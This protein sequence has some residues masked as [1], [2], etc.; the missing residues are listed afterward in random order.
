MKKGNFR[1]IL[2]AVMCLVMSCFSLSQ[3]AAEE[4]RETNYATVGENLVWTTTSVHYELNEFD[5]PTDTLVVK[6]Y[7]VNYSNKYV[8][9]F[10][11]LN[12]IVTV[13]KKDSNEEARINAVFKNF[14]ASIEPRSVKN[15]T[16]RIENAQ[17]LYPIGKAGTL[18]GHMKW[19]QSDAAG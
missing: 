1:A 8:N 19:K 12:L 14:E 13:T 4:I 9:Y 17:V 3:A 7:F 6:G 11:D 10:Y 15:H 5:M 2:C 16:F 18:Q